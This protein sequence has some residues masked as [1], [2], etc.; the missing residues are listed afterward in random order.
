MKIHSQAPVRI[1]LIGGGT[2]VNPFAAQHGGKVL[3]LA[4]NLYHQVT[5]E[6]VEEQGLLHIVQEALN[7]VLKHTRTSQAWVRLHLQEPF[8]M[9]IEDQGQGFDLQHSQRSGH[10]GLE[11]MRGW[12]TEIGWVLQIE[13]S[14]GAGTRVRVH[15]PEFEEIRDDIS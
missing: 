8:C 12:A 4:I 7:N 9:E 2:D 11:S 3:S 15:K 13:T 10:M 5:L 1:G 14:S 6:P